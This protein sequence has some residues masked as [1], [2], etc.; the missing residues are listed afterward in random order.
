MQCPYHRANLD[1]D[2]VVALMGLP[3]VVLCTLLRTSFIGGR[4]VLHAR[5]HTWRRCSSARASIAGAL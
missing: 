5:G 3:I 2:H 4:Q 1:G